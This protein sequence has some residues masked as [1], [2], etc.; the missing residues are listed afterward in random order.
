MSWSWEFIKADGS[1]HATL[2]VAFAQ[3]NEFHSR[4]DAESWIGVVFED[5]LDVDVEAVKLKNDSGAE[6]YQMDLNP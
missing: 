1:T 4:S 5:L 2:P 6:V 3:D